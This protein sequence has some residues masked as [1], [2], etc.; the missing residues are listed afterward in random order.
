MDN[1]KQYIDSITVP[2][3]QK[4]ARYVLEGLSDDIITLN[5]SEIEKLIL[6]RNPNSP[7]VIV[8]IT[9][10]LG[11]YGK[12]LKEQ[13]IDDGSFGDLVSKLDKDKLWSQAKPT[14]K[15]K[16]ISN[17]RYQQVVRDIESYEELNA[18][19]YA[20]LLRCIY[21]GIYNEDMSV[22]KNL[23]ASDIQG[24]IVTLHEDNGHSY[25]LKISQDLANS[26]IQLSRVHVWERRNRYGIC[27]IDTKGLYADS[28]FKVE[29]RRLKKKS[30]S[31]ST[32]FSY[33]AKLRKIMDEHLEFKMIPLQIYVSGIMHRILLQLQ[34]RNISV[35]EAFSGNSHDRVVH[36]IIEKELIRCNYSSGIF[37][38]REMVKGHL[39]SFI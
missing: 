8:T 23:R 38:F 36:E 6:S 2:N 26:L 11:A 4:V 7:K 3:T 10:I 34:L 17:R 31:D 16:Y 1:I 37:N 15:K 28:V 20:L 14:A 22:L 39:D 27:K 32:R 25:E 13:K 30:D 21:E 35:E 24:S 19:Y 12:W 18:S 29:Y 33:Y 5:Q 9:Y